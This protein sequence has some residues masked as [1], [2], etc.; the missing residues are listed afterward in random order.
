[1]G[2][3]RDPEQVGTAT[4]SKA[5]LAYQAILERIQQG[6]FAPASRLVLAQLAT[7]LD[8]SVVPV[9]EAIRRL[10]HDGL[11]SYARNV[12]ATVVGID[13]VEYRYTMETLALVEGFSTAQCAP[14]VT[15]E[16]IERARTIND[17]MRSLLEDFDPMEFTALNKEF[18][19][20]LFEH[21]QNPHILD[22]V[23]RGWNRLAA[24]RSST[25][26]YVPGRANASVDEHDHLLDLIVAGAP[27]EAI[28]SAARQHRA[29]TLDAYL[30]RVSETR[31]TNHSHPTADREAHR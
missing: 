28:E 24:L 20:T 7:E 14:L 12:G 23:H 8:M 10:Q 11:V 31:S 15:A 19:S 30:D 25:F 27:F 13:P 5:D 4:R 1:M 17:R 16:E 3:A 18:H 9:R 2:F 29:N 22:L 21:H 6:R 26:A